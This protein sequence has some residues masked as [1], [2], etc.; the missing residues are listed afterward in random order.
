MEYNLRSL[1][2]VSQYRNEGSVSFGSGQ[3]RQPLANTSSH[4]SERTH[5]SP[6]DSQSPPAAASLGRNT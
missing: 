2:S 1:Q 6:T 3:S 5:S 4:V